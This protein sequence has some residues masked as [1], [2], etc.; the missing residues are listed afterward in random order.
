MGNFERAPAG[1]KYPF[2]KWIWAA[3]LEVCPWVVEKLQ[4]PLLLGI[5][6]QVFLG[7]VPGRI[8]TLVAAPVGGAE[9]AALQ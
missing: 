5:V 3:V 1:S 7:S 9:S 6:S 2:K 4:A 8:A